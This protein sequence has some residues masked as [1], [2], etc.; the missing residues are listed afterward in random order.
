MEAERAIYEDG[1]EAPALEASW[2][3]PYH[4]DRRLEARAEP[5]RD[6]RSDAP[7]RTEA[8]FYHRRGKRALDIVLGLPLT[9]IAAPIVLLLAGLIV[10]THGWPPFY[11]ALR[12]GKD[13]REFRMWK[14]R[15]MVR[16]ADDRLRL[17]R[18]EHHELA[19]EYSEN[20]KLRADPRIT[21]LG[22]FLRRSSL[23][24]LPQLWNVIRGEMSLVGP[25]PYYL[26]ELECFPHMLPDISSVRPGLTGPWQV[27]GRNELTP[28]N[29]MLLDRHYARTC[30][31]KSDAVYLVRTSLPLI[32]ANG[33]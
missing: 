33:R 23:D 2:G 30:S 8:S 24:E 27:G 19:A 1:M 14:L 25:R 12:A 31:L 22:R 6:Q 5:R 9:L 17:W 26:S 16:D 32:K 7:A 13:G 28:A 29:R 4:R 3:A 20:F 21:R 15:T 18:E 10:L 11:G